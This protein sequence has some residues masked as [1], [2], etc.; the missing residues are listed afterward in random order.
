MKGA[1]V[2]ERQKC[3]KKNNNNKKNETKDAATLR[4]MQ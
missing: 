4:K 2:K 1:K 3:S